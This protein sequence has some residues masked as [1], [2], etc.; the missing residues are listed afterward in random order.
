MTYLFT[1]YNYQFFY[2]SEDDTYYRTYDNLNVGIHIFSVWD[3]CGTEWKETEKFDYIEP[4]NI[5]YYIGSNL[6][7]F[8]EMCEYYTEKLIFNKL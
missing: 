1:R 2:N 6:N 5:R 4:E 8:S 3:R 7:T